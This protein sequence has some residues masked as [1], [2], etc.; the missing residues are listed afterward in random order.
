MVYVMFSMSQPLK[1]EYD[2]KVAAEIDKYKKGTRHVSRVV[3]HMFTGS[4]QKQSHAHRVK[5]C[6]WPLN[7][8]VVHHRMSC[9]DK[10]TVWWSL[11]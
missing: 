2:Q 4:Q 6:L 8:R 9:P 11:I 5:I 10:S 3:H 7:L 1:G